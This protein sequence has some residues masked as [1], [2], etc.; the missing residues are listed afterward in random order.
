MYLFLTE[1]KE[2][3]NSKVVFLVKATG[4]IGDVIQTSLKSRLNLLLISARQEF[5]SWV[6][7][8]MYAQ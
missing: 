3:I 5:H 1:S 2:F 8:D 6:S 7:A 4:D